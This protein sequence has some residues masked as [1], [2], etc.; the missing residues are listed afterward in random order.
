[1]PAQLPSSLFSALSASSANSALILNFLR[2]L[3]FELSTGHPVKDAHPERARRGGRVEGSLR[4]SP[5][6]NHSRTY[7]RLARKSN[8]SRTYAKTGGWEGLLQDALAYNSFVFFGYVNQ[9]IIV[10]AP[11]FSFL[12]ARRR[13]NPRA[14][15]GMTVPQ[16]KAPASES[17]HYNGGRAARGRTR[18]K[19]KALLLP[20][21]SRYSLATFGAFAF[22]TDSESNQPLPLPSGIGTT[23][24]PRKKTTARWRA[25]RRAL[26]RT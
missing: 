3:N 15:S 18:G 23:C 17:G 11:T 5:K 14:Q 10:G 2:F 16:A 12:H 26:R 13:R 6:S 8:Y 4:P 21:R 22:I 24:E 19:K 7:A 25:L 1:M 20:Q 9:F